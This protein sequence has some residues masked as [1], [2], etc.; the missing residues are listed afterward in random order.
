MRVVVVGAGVAGLTAARDLDAAGHDVVVL[1]G[2]GSI[3][4][5]LAR[6][7]VAGVEVDTGAEAMVAR[8]PEGVGL[9][10]DLGL[11]TGAVKRYLSD[12]TAKLRAAL[13]PDA[14]DDGPAATTLL[15]ISPTGRTAR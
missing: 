4:G 7:R 11:S 13:G 10:R 9:A 8:R 14:V 15:T 1:E 6:H 2:A 5:K 3:G 12:A